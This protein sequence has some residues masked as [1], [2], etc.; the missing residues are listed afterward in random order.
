MSRLKAEWE[1]TGAAHLAKIGELKAHM[2][3]T[4]SRVLQEALYKVIWS[5]AFA[6]YVNSYGMA[7]AASA[8]TNVVKLIRIDF[9]EID[10]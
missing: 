3:V 7:L 10:I 5:K 8:T 9:I 6:K 2:V 4:Q 1:K